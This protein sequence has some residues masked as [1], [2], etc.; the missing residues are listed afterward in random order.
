MNKDLTLK[1][2][3]GISVAGLLFSGYLS[4]GEL[5][6]KACPLGSCSY[7]LGLPVCIYGFVM[8][9]AVFIF[10]LAGLKSKK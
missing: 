7:L 6:K 8:Y 1:I 4:Y 3:L 5:I 10:S 9:L 2:I